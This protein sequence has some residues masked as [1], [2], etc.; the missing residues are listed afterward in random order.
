[1]GARRRNA[2]GGLALSLLAHA[3]ALTALIAGLR[4]YQPPAATPPI[5]LQLLPPLFAQR[6]PVKPVP[7]KP[8]ASTRAAAPAAP[9]SA[10]AVAAAPAARPVETPEPSIANAEQL[11]GVLRGL[12]GCDRPA[13]LKEDERRAC[14]QRASRPAMAL[15]TVDPDNRARYVAAQNREP[16]LAKKPHNGCVLRVGDQDEGTTS[17]GG[18]IAAGIACAWS[19]W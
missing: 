3:L 18:S 10:S 4:V 5:E 9:P 6:P 12:L 14:D 8:A 1:M 17:Q 2:A 16:F 11:R 13:T 15:S 19:F 7:S